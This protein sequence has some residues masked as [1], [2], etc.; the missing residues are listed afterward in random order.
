MRPTFLTPSRALPRRL[1]AVGLVASALLGGC[2]H[3]DVPLAHN[4]PA[5]SQPK[6]R[7]AHHWDVLATD[8]AQRIAN[9]LSELPAS[10]NEGPAAAGAATLVGHPLRLSPAQTAPFQR[11]FHALLTHRLVSLGVTLVQAEPQ[12]QIDVDVQ[13]IEHASRAA[14]RS[15]MPS[16]QLA[17]SV[18]VVRDWV[19]HTQTATTGVLSA[20]ALGAISDA[21]RQALQGS[22]SGGPT[23]TEVLVTTRVTLQGRLAATT[24]DI[25]YIEAEDSALYLPLPEP[26]PPPPPAPVKTWTV[27]AP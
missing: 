9:R 16:T 13:V 14:N 11:A 3:L 2:T 12:G 22:A 15:P 24:A 23:R 4:Y 27:V 25:Y 5:S 8:V 10:A 20:L 21:S 7:S 26:P 1:L 6:A 17:A 18:A 19:V